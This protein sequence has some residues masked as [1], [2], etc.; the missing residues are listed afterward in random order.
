[1]SLRK[2]RMPRGDQ[3]YLGLPPGLV[4]VWLDCDGV[5]ADGRQLAVSGW[6]SGVPSSLR[7]PCNT[8]LYSQEYGADPA[9]WDPSLPVPTRTS[10][11]NQST[12]QTRAVQIQRDSDSRCLA[13]PIHISNTL[14]HSIHSALA[15][16]CCRARALARGCGAFSPRARRTPAYLVPSI[17]S[18]THARCAPSQTTYLWSTLG[19]LQPGLD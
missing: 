1:M 3:G 12:S 7:C 10:F 6:V 2:E 4:R 13:A 18:S 16:G 9:A 19:S 14:E 17:T 11:N 5:W 15:R 8:V